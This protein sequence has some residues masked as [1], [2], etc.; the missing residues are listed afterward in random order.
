LQVLETVEDRFGQVDEAL[1]QADT[2]E[3]EQRNEQRR[4]AAASQSTTPAKGAAGAQQL[5]AAASRL[6]QHSP[7]RP[8]Q[9]RLS[10]T[11][12]HSPPPEIIELD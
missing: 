4:L 10:R 8:A 3:W 2:R 9:Q 7:A 11:L 1:Q 5:V 6:L 12:Y